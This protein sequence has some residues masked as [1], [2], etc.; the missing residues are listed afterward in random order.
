MVL[1]TSILC[2]GT[3]FG[4]HPC[5]VGLVSGTGGKDVFLLSEVLKRYFLF[6]VYNNSIFIKSQNHYFCNTC[7]KVLY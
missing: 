2:T 6:A 4:M 1:C 5:D 7:T 3:V